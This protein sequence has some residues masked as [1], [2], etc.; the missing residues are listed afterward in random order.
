MESSPSR[1]V[2]AEVVEDHVPDEP[3]I[4]VQDRVVPEAT[5]RAASLEIQEAEETRA[6]LS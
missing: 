2:A 4:A 6:S 5:T 3:A 1:P